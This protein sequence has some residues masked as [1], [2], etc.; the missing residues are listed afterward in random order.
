[1]SFKLTAVLMAMLALLAGTAYALERTK[2]KVEKPPT[3]YLYKFKYEDISRIDLTVAD[4]GLC[5]QEK[6]VG[7]GAAWVFCGPE[8]SDA[9]TV[10]ASNIQLIMSGPAYDRIVAA[11]ETAAA[12]FA[13]YGLSKAP[14]TAAIT[15][16]DGRTHKVLLGDK[17]PDGKFHYAKN[18]D[19][20]TIYLVDKV[21]G[22]ELTRVVNNPPVKQPT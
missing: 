5:V 3:N 21:W 10:S 1:M 11:G 13:E 15:M 19:S 6:T 22:D 16:K 7:D 20:D 12:R 8:A 14:I 2:P 4:K 17:T 18:A 9:D